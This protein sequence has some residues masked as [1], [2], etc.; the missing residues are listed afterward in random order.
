MRTSEM[1]TGAAVFPA[2]RDGAALGGG[3]FGMGGRERLGFGRGRLRE[4][5]EPSKAFLLTPGK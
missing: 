5:Y 1:G 4:Y 2:F 3:F